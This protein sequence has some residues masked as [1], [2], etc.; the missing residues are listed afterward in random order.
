MSALTKFLLDESRMPTPLVQHRGRPA[1]A[2]GA[3]AAPGHAAAGRAGRPGAAVP[4]GADRAGGLDRARDPDP[5]TGARGVPPVAPVAAVPRA[6]A[7][8][9]ARHAGAA[10][11][12]STKACRRPAAT[13]P[14]PRCR[15]PGTTPQ[16]GVKKLTTE[17]GAGQWGSALAF[18]GALFGIEVKVFQVRVSLRPEAV[19]ARADGDLR[20]DA[21]S[22]R[23]R[24]RPTPAARS[25]PRTRTTRARWASRSARRS[26]SRPPTTTPSTRSARCSTTC[27][28]TRPSS[29]RRRCCRWRWPATTR[30]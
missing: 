9:G 21:A 24:T 1:D 3:A 23:R 20:R 18:A 16:A 6:S 14:T 30:T 15:R 4:D 26:R 10:S 5:G 22:R 8:E 27:C 13:S 2:A 12:T 7:G 19:P 25:W 17:T 28:C 11:T 29:A